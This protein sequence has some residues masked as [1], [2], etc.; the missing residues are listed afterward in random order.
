MVI[1]RN[2]KRSG[3]TSIYYFYDDFGGS[4]YSNI[5]WAT[6]GTG[7]SLAL[8]TDGS[9]RVRA[10]SNNNYEMYQNDL[11]DFSV[12]KL[13]TIT[14]KFKI[15]SLSS[16]RGEVGFEEASPNQLTNWIALYYDPDQ[17]N[18]WQAAC[19]DD[20]VST[21]IDTGI[22]A[23]TNYHEFRIECTSSIVNFFI[24]GANVGNITT[25]IPTGMLQPYTWVRSQSGGSKDLFF[26]WLECTGE[27]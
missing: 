1:F 18:N 10:T 9:I 11:T 25:N 15:G 8:Q 23:D 12:A 21:I 2:S 20:D 4:L 24:D 6:R 26:D 16:M 5:F 19:E 27:R 17:N 13:C 14:S 7:G 3:S 22:L